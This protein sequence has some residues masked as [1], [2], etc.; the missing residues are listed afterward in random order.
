MQRLISLLFFLPLLAA[1]Q[2][3]WVRLEFQS[4][5]Y[6]EE[7]TWNIYE[8]GSDES[9]ASGGPYA[10]STYAEHTIPLPSG[11]YNLVVDDAFGD[12]I[13]CGFGEGWFKL[14]NDCGLDISVFDFDTQQVTVPFF[15]DPCDLPIPGCTDEASNNY[16]PWATVDNGS[17]NVSECPEGQAFVSME[18]TLDNWPMAS[19]SSLQT[20][21]ETDLTGLQAEVRTEAW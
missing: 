6:G 14:N 16:N 3:S 12:G 8:V 4:D 21:T 11:E 9:L 10:D 15:L 17:C 5:A 18:L 7:S 19:S 20:L 2:P 13:C 1:A